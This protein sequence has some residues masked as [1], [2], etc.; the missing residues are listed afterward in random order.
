MVL[1]LLDGGYSHVSSW[2]HFGPFFH[3]SGFSPLIKSK[4]NSHNSDHIIPPL[5]FARQSAAFYIKK[6]AERGVRE[7]FQEKPKK[8]FW[9]SKFVKQRCPPI[10]QL[11]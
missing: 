4:S 10:H 7:R 2:F 1:V 5:H 3:F 6:K 8:T 11:P 9:I